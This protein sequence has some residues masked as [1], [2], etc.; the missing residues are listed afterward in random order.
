VKGGTTVS[1]VLKSFGWASALVIFAGAAQPLRA[2]GIV[3]EVQYLH[4]DGLGSARAVTDANGQLVAGETRDY[5]PFGEEWCVNAPCSGVTPGQPKRYTGKERDAETGLDYFGARYYRAP[6]GRFT[7]IDPVFSW[8][9]S[10]V[11]PEQWN[12]YAYA[13]NNPLR[14]VDSD[15]RQVAEAIRQLGQ[16]AQRFPDQRVVA[17]GGV[18]IIVAANVDKIV[19]IGQAVADSGAF[20]GAAPV[21]YPG[22]DIYLDQR[23]AG[24]Y[25]SK[26][27][28]QIRAEWEKANG[29]PWPKDQKTGKNQDVS[30]EPQAKADGGTDDLSN[31][32]P[33]PHDEHVEHHKQQGDFRRWGKRRKQPSPQPSPAPTN[34][35]PTE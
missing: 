17:V 34:T 27:S 32:Q 13:R 33:R 5:L 3:S 16:D 29:Q 24:V 35:P 22:I 12:R 4:V 26:S 31:I 28:A 1:C 19:A 15:G 9:E 8:Q 6:L 2:A 20:S 11:D 18:L 30:H 7:A 10:I 25:Y 23:M 21:T 14:Y